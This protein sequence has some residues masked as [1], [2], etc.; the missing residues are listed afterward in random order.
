VNFAAINLC[1]PSQR[2]FIVVISLTIQSGNFWIHTP[3]LSYLFHDAGYYLKSWLLLSLSKNI[4]QNG[5]LD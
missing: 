4:P 2:V 5:V 1:V 3:I